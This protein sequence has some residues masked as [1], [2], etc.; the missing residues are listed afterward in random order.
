MS[1]TTPDAIAEQVLRRWNRGDILAAQITGDALFPLEIRLK[2]PGPRDVANRFGEVQDWTRALSA[3]SRENRGFGFELR[4]ETLRN[5]VQGSNE[6]P[7]AAILP[8]ESDALRLIRRQAEAARFATIAETTLVWYPALRDWLTRRALVA[9]KHVD[10][11][12]RILAVLDWFVAHPNSGLYLRQLDIPGVDTKFI[13]ARRGLLTELLDVVLPEAAVDRSASGVKGFQQRFGLRSETP[14]LRFRLLDPQLYIRGLSDLSL[15]PEEF[16][17]LELPLRR[18]FITENRTN[19]LAFPDHPGSM[20]VF[21]LG[22]GL[23][24]LIET[25]WL[26]ELDIVYWGDIDTHGF[27][28]LDRLRTMLPQ[29]RSLLMDRAT[30]DAHRPLWGQEPAD[31][32]HT[33]ALS[34]LTA[35][36][37][38]LFDEL[39]YDRIGERVRLEQ[40][41]IAFSWL[42]NA[43]SNL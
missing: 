36:E 3:A 31:K 24:R 20:V 2:R 33:A 5:R 15:L 40:E 9:L 41:R 11:W 35:S 23:D 30:L 1:W 7:V 17:K 13:E 22:Y 32:R 18:L 26:R 6:L 10:A 39:R 43:L 16:A 8:S 21:G 12:Q 42:E 34:R 37:T 29:A 14:L 38:T 19:G 4:H 27:R 28:I 25:P